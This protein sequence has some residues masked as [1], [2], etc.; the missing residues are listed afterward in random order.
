MFNIFKGKQEKIEDFQ[1][2]L[3][4]LKTNFLSVNIKGTKLTAMFTSTN[5][6]N[7][8]EIENNVIRFT[9]PNGKSF[10][11][12]KENVIKIFKE[13][14]KREILNQF[15]LSK[16]EIHKFPNIEEPQEGETKGQEWLKVTNFVL[17]NSYEKAAKDK[18]LLIEGNLY[19][20]KKEAQSDFEIRFQSYNLDYSYR[21]MS[22][23]KILL[24]VFDDKNNQRGTSKTASYIGEFYNNRPIILDQA[25][26][27]ISSCL[28]SSEF[29]IF[30]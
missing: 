8:F 22:T 16:K 15:E 21:F 27:L 30:S 1:K 26:S 3:V 9:N 13:I 10:S 24:N 19:I 25:L 7:L 12:N 18:D 5:K 17:S 6:N 29:K 23:G 28:K 4:S 20:G 11:S 14:L 2:E